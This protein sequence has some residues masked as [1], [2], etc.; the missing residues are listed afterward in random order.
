M[1][2]YAPFPDNVDIILDECIP[3]KL[4]QLLPASINCYAIQTS[5][6]EG[7]SNGILIDYCSDSAANLLVTCDKPMVWQQWKKI[8]HKDICVVVLNV[9]NNIP[10]LMPLIGFAGSVYSEQVWLHGCFYVINEDNKMY[11]ITDCSDVERPDAFQVGK[12]WVSGQ[13]IRELNKEP[14]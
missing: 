14:R 5:V 12:Y 6:Y 8:T 3:A 10:A 11:L 13:F 2:E 9:D 1:S 7:I 4:K